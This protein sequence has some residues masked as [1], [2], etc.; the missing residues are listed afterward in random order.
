MNGRITP[1]L[2]IYINSYK[3]GIIYKYFKFYFLKYKRLISRKGIM[4]EKA[5]YISGLLN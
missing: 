2:K 1:M 5:L 4:I 3:I